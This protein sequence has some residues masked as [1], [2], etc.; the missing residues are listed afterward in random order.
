MVTKKAEE[1]NIAR[2]TFREF[3][4]TSRIQNERVKYVYIYEDV[5]HNFI[6]ALTKGN[7][8]RSK[9]KVEVR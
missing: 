4:Q 9:V 8:T 5:Q 3:A 1:H 6:K 7:E 2:E